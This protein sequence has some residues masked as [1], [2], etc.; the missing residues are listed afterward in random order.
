MTGENI[1]CIF[2]IVE[3][4]GEDNS[5]E[6]DSEDSGIVKKSVEPPAREELFV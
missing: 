3:D 5:Y 6:C 4:H 1:L 2:G